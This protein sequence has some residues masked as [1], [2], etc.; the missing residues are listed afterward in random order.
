MILI[1]FHWIMQN[2]THYRFGC[3]SVA[4][5]HLFLGCEI[6]RSLLWAP[7]T[8]R[9]RGILYLAW[10]PEVLASWYR[11]WG[12]LGHEVSSLWLFHHRSL[13]PL[14][15]LILISKGTAEVHVCVCACLHEQVHPCIYVCVYVLVS[16][17]AGN[18]VLWGMMMMNDVLP[19]KCSWIVN[20]PSISLWWKEKSL[21]RDTE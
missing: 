10:G 4:A 18:T 14:L 8:Q 9:C 7:F 6:L 5:V 12:V 1:H 13:L 17:T 11:A 15:L 3:N 19:F 21:F 2:E 16:D 20:N